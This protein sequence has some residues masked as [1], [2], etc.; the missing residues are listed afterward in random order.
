M[1][2]TLLCCKFHLQYSYYTILHKSVNKK[3][4]E[5]SMNGIHKLFTKNKNGTDIIGLRK[6]GTI[7]NI[8]TDVLSPLSPLFD[9]NLFKN[10][11]NVE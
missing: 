3:N 10:I 9:Q 4:S 1:T 11:F 7:R 6:Y 8:R 2:K 5:E